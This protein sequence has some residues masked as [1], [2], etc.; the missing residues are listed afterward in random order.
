[1]PVSVNQNGFLF[2]EFRW[3]GVRCREGTKL[4]DTPENRRILQKKM[5]LIDGEIALGTFD[6]SRHFPDGNKIRIFGKPKPNITFGEFTRKWIEDRKPRFKK[7]HWKNINYFLEGEILPY[8]GPLK[9][10]EIMEEHVE[11]FITEV[12]E[13][14]GIKKDKIGGKGV[15]NYLVLLRTILNT[16]RRRRLIP[17]NPTQFVEKLDEDPPDIDPLS[18]EEVAVFFRSVPKKYYNYF[19]TAFLTG[20]RPNEQ[21]ALKLHNVDFVHMKISVR[22]GRVCGEEG[23]PKT[24]GSIRDIDMLPPVQ[25]VMLKQRAIVL[26]ASQYVF[27]NAVGGALDTANLRNRVWYPTLEEAGIRLRTLYQTRHTFATLMLGSGENPEWV[28]KMLGHSTIRML[29]KYSKFIPNLT[30][31]DGSAFMK[32][33]QDKMSRSTPQI[34][35][36]FGQCLDEKKGLVSQPFESFGG[37]EGDRTPDPK[38]ASLVLSQLSYSPMCFK[39]FRMI[40]PGQR[41]VKVLSYNYLLTLKMIKPMM[42]LLLRPGG[43]F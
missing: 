1:V 13:R 20:M 40:S 9:L 22:E 5:N 18:M 29:Q 24:R 19:F 17:E 2:F 34:W 39:L 37:A 14:K 27:P 3:K 16:A 15:N 31:Q 28:A 38:T 41:D 11:S 10:D 33:F 21:I 42:R 7:S 23:L 43:L 30:R 12:S 32:V 8:F 35:P 6:Y 36:M 25:Q 26:W 4:Q